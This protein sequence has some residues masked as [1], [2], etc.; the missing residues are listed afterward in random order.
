MLHTV[1][2]LAY[3]SLI[4]SVS[5][6]VNYITHGEVNIS[7]NQSELK[8]IGMQKRFGGLSDFGHIQSFNSGSVVLKL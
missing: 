2:I 1:C 8:K 6:S 3:V 7:H 5:I 4:I